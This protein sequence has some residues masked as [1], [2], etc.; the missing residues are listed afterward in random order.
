M[1]IGN[2]RNSQLLQK[3]SEAF[4]TTPQRCQQVLDQYLY[5]NMEAKATQKQKKLRNIS[6]EVIQKIIDFKKEKPHQ[7]D[8]KMTQSLTRA[9][10]HSDEKDSRSHQRKNSGGSTCSGASTYMVGQRS[11]QEF[12]QQLR[13]SSKSSLDRCAPS[14]A[15]MDR[16]PSSKKNVKHLKTIYL[17]K[18][19]SRINQKGSQAGPCRTSV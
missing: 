19:M 2:P 15:F 4:A 12:A 11:S 17:K 8:G 7:A 16:S 5:S 14:Q 10:K 9:A 1:P 18:Q 13:C 3:K 6:S